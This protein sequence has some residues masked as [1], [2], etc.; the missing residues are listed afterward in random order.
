[1]YN[2]HELNS[3]EE[4][5]NKEQVRKAFDQLQ[6]GERKMV[7]CE[8]SAIKELSRAV[9]DF[10]WKEVTPFCFLI[11]KEI[12]KSMSMKSAIERLCETYKGGR[13]KAPYPDAYVRT[14]ISTYN[15]K[16]GTRFKVSA[17][18]G[19]VYIYS[20][21]SDQKYITQEQYEMVREEYRLKL[22]ELKKRIRTPEFFEMQDEDYD[23]GL[24]EASDAELDE[25]YRDPAPQQPPYAVT[26]QEPVRKKE[27]VECQVCHD[28]FMQFHFDQYICEECEAKG[29]TAAPAKEQE[30]LT[31][32]CTNC[33]DEFF[34]QGSSS[35]CADCLDEEG[36]I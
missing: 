1:M 32:L 33:G 21:M 31:T 9:S 8:P 15:K 3:M 36:M 16:H 20:D 28:N 13:T 22:T 6:P 11:E 12:T 5:L 4:V 35:L 18:D 19:E 26:Y 34:R 10:K 17:R 29:H 30:S 27:I 14:I 7:S 24:G 2:K 25:G 23:N